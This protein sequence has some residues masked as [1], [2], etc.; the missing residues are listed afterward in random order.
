[1]L[2]T[3]YPPAKSTPTVLPP[4]LKRDVL[5]LIG[6]WLLVAVFDRTWFWLDQMPPHWDEGD[7]LSRALNHWRV[8]QNPQWFSGEWW[9]TLWQQAP[10][11]RAPL[12]YLLTAPYFTLFGPTTDSAVTVN[13]FFTAV[14]LVSVYAMGRRLFNNNVGLWAAGLSL[15]TPLLG[16]LRLDYMLDYGLT[17]VTAFTA[18]GLTYWWTS[19]RRQGQWGFTLLWGV[20][21]GLMLLARTSGLLFVVAMVGWLGLL[22]VLGR[23]WQRILQLMAGIVVGIAVIWPWFSTSWLTITSTTIESTSHGITLMGSPQANSLAGWLFYP[24]ELPGMLSSPVLFL[25]LAAALFALVGLWVP[26]PALKPQALANTT[27]SPRQAWLWLGGIILVIL[28]FGA[29]GSNKQP[30]LL[31]PVVPLMSIALARL[32]WW[33]QDLTWQALRWLAATAST[34]LL[35]WTTF[36]V[37]GAGLLPNRPHWFPYTGEPWPHEE[38]IAAMAEATPH[39]EINL[40]TIPNTPEIQPF[41]LGF[42]GGAADFQV[43]TRELGLWTWSTEQDA[44][45]LD[46]YITKTGAQGPLLNEEARAQINAAVANAPELEVWQTWPLPDGSEATIHRRRQPWVEV[47]PLNQPV[48]QVRLAEVTIPPQVTAG[49]ITPVTYRMIGPWEDLK[50]GL[51]LLSWTSNQASNPPR[52][53]SDH[54]IGMGRLYGDEDSNA[55][56]E[57]VERLGVAPPVDLPPGNYRL[58]ATFVHRDT[59]ASYPIEVP[60]ITVE[61]LPGPSDGEQLPPVSPPL[62]LVTVLRHLSQGL[63]TGEL[64]SVFNDVGRIG[65]YDPALD[66]LRQTEEAM[67]FRL[68]AHPDNLEWLYGKALSQVLQQDAPAAIATLTR[69]TEVVP[70]NPYH[71]AYLGLVHLYSWQPRQAQAVLDRAA[72][73]DPDIPELKLLQAA[74]AIMQLQIPKGLDL[75]KQ[76]DVL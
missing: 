68:Q 4:S 47:E 17:T 51:I 73:I 58:E 2:P 7:H 66:Y 76:G 35:L 9:R 16:Q 36:P 65:Q 15:L 30:R 60:N 39:L 52:W 56:F 37:P 31:A 62:D 10:T 53:I 32:L 28:V 75:L 25:A 26:W 1:M 63:A 13:L 59:Q 48:D 24:K 70:E 20:G 43:S 71:W 40:G 23:Q 49:Q 46:W 3:A 41:S 64:E 38:M 67:D 44:R 29:I 11:Q 54:G 18:M 61:V 8:L 33:R 19:Q 14:L 42:Y 50:N 5:I 34:I 21:V 72:A 45:A 22:C 57:V 12:V 6:L 27:T 74:A 69:L 55:G